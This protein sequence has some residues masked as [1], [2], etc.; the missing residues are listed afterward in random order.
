MLGPAVR[1]RPA[2]AALA[3]VVPAGPGVAAPDPDGPVQAVAPA[4]GNPPAVR[5]ERDSPFARPLRVQLAQDRAGGGVVEDDRPPAAGG[6]DCPVRAEGD[7]P[8]PAGA[9]GPA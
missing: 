6:Y 3:L 2:V 5:A 4:A 7:P 8:A 1:G 9:G